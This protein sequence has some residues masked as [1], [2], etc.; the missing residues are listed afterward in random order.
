MKDVNGGDVKQGSL[1]DCWI[2]ASM[3]AL[4]NVEDG[5]QRICVAHNTS[6]RLCVFLV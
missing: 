1:G 4:A 2:M 5:I 3:T 6:K